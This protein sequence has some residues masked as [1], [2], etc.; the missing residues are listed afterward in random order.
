[1]GTGT[2]NGLWCSLM[3]CRVRD[4]DG[5]KQGFVVQSEAMQEQGWV[6]GQAGVCSA[7]RGD[8]AETVTSDREAVTV[9]GPLRV[10]GLAVSV[11]LLLLLYIIIRVDW[12]F[13]VHFT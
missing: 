13:D 10:P 4:G 5:A 8:A 6:R 3:R 9:A 2:G 12:E 7:V 1:M 11:C